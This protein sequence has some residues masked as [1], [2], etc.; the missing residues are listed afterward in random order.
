[1]VDREESA[2]TIAKGML[3]ILTEGAVVALA[4]KS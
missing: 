1:M 2:M 4:A 3:G